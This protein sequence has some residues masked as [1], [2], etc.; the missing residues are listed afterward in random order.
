MTFCPETEDIS[1]FY[2]YLDSKKAKKDIDTS[3]S[4]DAPHLQNAFTNEE[5]LKLR[6]GNEN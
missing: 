2:L 3:K 6:T 1:H 4:G 5:S